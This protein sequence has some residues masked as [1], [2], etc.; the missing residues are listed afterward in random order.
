MLNGLQTYYT[1]TSRDTYRRDRMSERTGDFWTPNLESLKALILER[2]ALCVECGEPYRAQLAW[3]RYCRRCQIVLL[4]AE[5]SAEQRNAAA[6]EAER[7]GRELSRRRAWLNLYNAKVCTFANLKPRPKE[8]PA[9]AEVK[10]TVEAWSRGE[11]EPFLTLAGEPGTAKSH[12]AEAAL[13]VVFER[14]EAARFE[15]VS[16]L[17]TRLRDA[18]A[19]DGNQDKL[20]G[21]MIDTP[22]LV[23]DDLGR[24][25]NSPWVKDRI[26]T[27]IN[28]RYR[29]KRRTILTTNLSEQQLAD[30]LDQP[31]SDRVFDTGSGVVRV[32]V[33]VGKSYRTG[34]IA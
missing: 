28:A 34:V 1:L 18:I 30:L 3:S 9:L 4:N 20:L 25:T 8:V 26:Y 6:V 5:L 23:L 10:R 31:L 22:W 29:R 32:C 17:L 7:Q 14:G 11:N 2:D 33:L 19:E 27:L 24:H 13:R 12:L 16:D 15:V 21:Q